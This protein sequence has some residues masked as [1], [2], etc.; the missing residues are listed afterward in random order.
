VSLLREFLA[1]YWLYRAAHG[2]IYAT[3]TAWRIAVQ[4]VPF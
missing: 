1:V 4:G 2:R 3:K